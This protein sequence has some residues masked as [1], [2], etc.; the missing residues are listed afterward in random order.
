MEA[1]FISLRKLHRDTYLFKYEKGK[2][3]M[4]KI[5]HLANL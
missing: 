2:K 5:H 1:K 3:Y 4:T